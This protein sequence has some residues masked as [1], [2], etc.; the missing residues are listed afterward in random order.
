[1]NGRLL[2]Y[3]ATGYTGRLVARRA[4]A[5]GL[6]VVVAGRDPDRVDELANELDVE[7]RTFEA[8]EAREALEDI[9]CLLNVAGPFR[10]TARPLMDACL[11]SGVHYLDTTAEFDTFVLAESLDRRASRAGIMLMSG[12]GWDVVPCDCL[13][14]HTARRVAEPEKVTIALR[15]TGGFSRGSLASSA[16]IEELGT[17]VRRSGELVRLDT[18]TPRTFDFG[19]GPEKCLPVPMGDL[20]TASR[21][22][23]LADIEVYLGTDDGFPATTTDGPTAEERARGHYHA[24][25]EVTGRDGQ[26]A[27]SLITTPT[28]YT[29]TQ[30]SS[31][32]IARRVLAGQFTAGYRTPASAYGAELATSIDGTTVT[33][34]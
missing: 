27:R 19:A 8:S 3:G 29:F 28:G 32:E 2:V 12:T 1:M 18:A 33:D 21:S 23:G 24:L 5:I 17:L 16:G 4:V 13:A 9:D 6:D 20:I 15:V 7:G 26:I 22:T 34:L 14:L 30:H 11:D 31:V 10:H 25:A